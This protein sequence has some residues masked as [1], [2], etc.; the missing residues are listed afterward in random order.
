[1][2][3]LK[4]MNVKKWA[5]FP[6]WES[7]GRPLKTK[8]NR[9]TVIFWNCGRNDPPL[10]GAMLKP[11]RTPN[12]C[13]RLTKSGLFWSCL[14]PLSGKWGCPKHKKRTTCQRQVVLDF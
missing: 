4:F 7:K 5:K 12:D 2:P 13:G 8:I 11:R 10:M 1:M 9:E 6:L 14:L 3:N